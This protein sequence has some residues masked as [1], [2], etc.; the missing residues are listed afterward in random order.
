MIDPDG[1]ERASIYFRDNDL[2]LLQIL[3]QQLQNRKL[4]KE[5]K[6]PAADAFFDILNRRREEWQF[7]LMGLQEELDAY[8]RQLEAQEK[9]ILGFPKE[10]SAEEIANGVNIA[11]IRFTR[12]YKIGVRENAKNQEY[13]R[14]M[15]N[16]ISL[17]KANFAPRN[18]KIEDYIPK[19][20][21]GERNS[22]YKL[23][24]YVVGL[25][26]NGLVLNNAGEIVLQKSFR[27]L[28][29]FEYL[30]S[31]IV[32]NN[33]QTE[34]SSN[35]V[36][37]VAAEIPL[38]SVASSL[39]P[40]L[41]PTANPIW[42]HGNREKQGLILIRRDKSGNRLLRYLPV[43][44]LTQI[45]NGDVIFQIEKWDSGFPLK[46]FEDPNF[47]T[48]DD[49]TEWLNNWHSE[50]D[51]LEAVHQTFY[52]NGIIGLTEQIDEQPIPSFD[53]KN[54]S[55][56]EKLIARMRTRQR[57]LL[58][59]DILVMANN[60]W[61]FDF[62]GFNPGGNHGSFFRISTHSVFM[63]AGGNKTNIPRGLSVTKPYDSL[64]FIPTV[65]ALM[66]KVD[67][68]GNPDKELYEKGF[69][70]FPGP[71]VEEI[72]DNNNNGK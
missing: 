16:L 31:L 62:V 14:I 20:S 57:N 41:L 59:A 18:L 11:N 35:L 10:Y 29:Y 69:R 52:S 21:V 7:T 48:P 47:N 33:V 36:D 70:K 61:N 5:L 23:Q 12:L 67:K 66:G 39:P 72:F 71:I 34:V 40:D 37:F 19:N 15:N 6:K 42:L 17:R 3:F 44:N 68:N 63:M 13:I 45:S 22:I 58:R 51:W 32:R 38:K 9:V 1:N 24:N 64:S 28:N 50:K 53:N 55:A 25:S 54:I 4:K 49:K 30:S 43:S 56:D 46:I 27:R 8:N 60:H 2:N 26:E 65:F